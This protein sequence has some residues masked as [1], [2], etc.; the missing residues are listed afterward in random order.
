MRC[1][2]NQGFLISSDIVMHSFYRETHESFSETA[3]ELCL[4]LVN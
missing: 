1:F 3:T 2:S 4:F